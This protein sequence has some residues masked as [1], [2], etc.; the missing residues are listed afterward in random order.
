MSRTAASLLPPAPVGAAL[1][2]GTRNRSI[3][4]GRVRR[5]RSG[6]IP[7]AGSTAR[8]PRLSSGRRWP[9][10][11]SIRRTVAAFGVRVGGVRGAGDRPGT[12]DRADAEQVGAP[13]PDDRVLAGSG[14]PGQFGD[15][16]P[17]QR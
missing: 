9:I 14:G 1:R 10:L 13:V 11:P 4:A 6:D 12:A 16:L 7:V 2:T 3:T 5:P 15:Q 17:V 8:I